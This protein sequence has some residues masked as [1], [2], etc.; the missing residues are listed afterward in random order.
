MTITPDTNVLVRSIMRDDPSQGEIA[1][2]VL[3]NASLI[4]LTL[5]CLCE[6]AWVLRSVYGLNRSEIAAAIRNVAQAANV[7]VNLNAVEA[8]LGFLSVGGDFAD[9]VI[10]YEG[11]WLGGETFVSFDKKAVTLAMNQGHEARLLA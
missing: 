8:G 4:A 9:G 10:G 11:R 1:A 5:P 3:R 6:F 7:M 2:Q